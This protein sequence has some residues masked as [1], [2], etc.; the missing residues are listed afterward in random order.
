MT[1][2]TVQAIFDEMDWNLLQKQKFQLI[3]LS[4][5]T[6]IAEEDYDTIRGIIHLIDSLQD[7]AVDNLG[8]PAEKVF[9]QKDD[10]N[11]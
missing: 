8:I 4:V 9:K 1:K 3:K 7:A 6:P 2:Q 11:L 10:E 5:N